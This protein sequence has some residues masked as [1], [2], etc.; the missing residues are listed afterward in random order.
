MQLTIFTIPAPGP[1]QIKNAVSYEQ[2]QDLTRL[3]AMSK[4]LDKI[5]EAARYLYGKKRGAWGRRTMADEKRSARI[6]NLSINYKNAVQ[7]YFKKYN[8][9]KLELNLLK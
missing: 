5:K 1:A 7:A 2:A 9:D 4:E 8:T 6:D 3:T